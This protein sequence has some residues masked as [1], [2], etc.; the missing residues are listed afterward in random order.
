[1]S[2]P[3]SSVEEVSELS[4]DDSPEMESSV[5]VEVD[6]FGALNEM[7]EGSGTEYFNYRP[8]S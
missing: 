4:Q 1:M 3:A 6:D 5:T 2:S 8:R 7:S